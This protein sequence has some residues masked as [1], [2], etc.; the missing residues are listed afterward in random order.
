LLLRSKSA[1]DFAIVW[2]LLPSE[3]SAMRENFRS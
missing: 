1:F 2:R 3:E